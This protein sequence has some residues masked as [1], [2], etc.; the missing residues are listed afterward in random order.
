MELQRVCSSNPS[1]LSGLDLTE[2]L[3]GPLNTEGE[4]FCFSPDTNCFLA[5][6]SHLHDPV[7][8]SEIN[9]QDGHG[10]DPEMKKGTYGHC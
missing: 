3:S 4:L 1:L 10:G 8:L 2:K 6:A 5:L 7:I 9:T